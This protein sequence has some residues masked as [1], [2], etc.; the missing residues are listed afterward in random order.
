MRGGSASA[1]TDSA[2]LP[3]AK[4]SEQR[5]IEAH[6]TRVGIT[7]QDL[8]RKSRPDQAQFFRDALAAQKN[9]V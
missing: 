8:L 9:S 1:I 3:D 6:L 2:G 4:V 5:T 7:L